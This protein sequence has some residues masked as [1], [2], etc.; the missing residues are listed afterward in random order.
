M[1]RANLEIADETT[2]TFPPI[3]GDNMVFIAVLHSGLC[4]ANTTASDDRDE[5]VQR[6]V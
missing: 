1:C 2:P 4:P 6:E 5:P 3:Y